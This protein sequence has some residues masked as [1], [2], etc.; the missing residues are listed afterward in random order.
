[1]RL[2]HRIGNVLVGM[3]V[4]VSMASAQS[5]V[6]IGKKNYLSSC[7]SPNNGAVYFI[8]NAAADGECVSTGASGLFKAAC[9]CGWDGATYAWAPLTSSGGE[10]DLSAYV[11]LAGDEDGQTIQGLTGNN[12]ARIELSLEGEVDKAALIGGGATYGFIYAYANGVYGASPDESTSFDL[13]NGGLD[14]TTNG[15]V[16]FY[17]STSTN[18][19]STAGWT[20]VNGSRVNVTSLQTPP[21]NA[22][23]PCPAGDT[24]DT[25]TYHYYCAATDT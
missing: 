3:L 9:Q 5:D 18:L 12:K 23:D 13:Y 15:A 8:T 17:G 14:L 24:I 4:F 25:A 22:N 1:M 16:Q 10:V 21:T 7:G 6:R 11:L 2:I 19:G 20:A